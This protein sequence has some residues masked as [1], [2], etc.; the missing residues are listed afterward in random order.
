MLNIGGVKVA[1]APIEAEIKRIEGI[2][3]AVIMSIAGLHEAG[4]L[5]AALEFDIMPPPL[6]AMQSAGEILAR[7]VAGFTMMPARSCRGP[8][9]ARSNVRKSRRCSG[10]RRPGN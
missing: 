8:N 2:R 7:H 1:P 4:V 5:L 3:D 10:A 6:S 9:R